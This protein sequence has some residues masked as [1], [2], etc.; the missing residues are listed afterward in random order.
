VTEFVRHRGVVKAE[1]SVQRRA[2]ALVH[3]DQALVGA[4]LREDGR[5]GFLRYF[6]PEDV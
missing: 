1:R 6:L 5:T 4:Y 2:T 3:D